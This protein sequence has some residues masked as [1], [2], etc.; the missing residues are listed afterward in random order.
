MTYLHNDVYPLILWVFDLL[1]QLYDVAVLEPFEDIATLVSYLNLQRTIKL[2]L[3]PRSA[4]Y[5]SLSS[6]NNRA[7]STHIPSHHPLFVPWK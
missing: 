1:D 2:T 5:P 7:V 3:L 4:S 6:W